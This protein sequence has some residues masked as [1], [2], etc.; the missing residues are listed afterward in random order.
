MK[1]IETER[2]ILRQ[3]TE[4]DAAFIFE[5]LNEP[6]WIQN[7]GDRH[8]RT[9]DDARAYIRNGPIA[10]YARNGFGL[11]LVLLKET[12]ESI[13]MCGLIKR[14]GLDDVD[15]G[16]AL[17]PRFWSKGF[18]IEAAQATKLYAKDVIDLKK[19]VAI[20]DPANEGSI[21]VLEKLGMHF[22]NMVR[23]SADDIEL[24]LFGVEL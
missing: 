2:L 17:L 21:R 10:S 24:K 13:G 18:A 4:D 15:I 16:Y 9:L 5:L 3:L 19:I 14:D 22:E 12:N 11:Y 8:I 1:I 6:S 7:I 23:L 20:V